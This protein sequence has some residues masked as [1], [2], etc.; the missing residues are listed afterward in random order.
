MVC[1][2][3]PMVPVG[4]VRDSAIPAGRPAHL[5]R[6][7]RRTTDFGRTGRRRGH[8]RF[9][10][11]HTRRPDVPE[12]QVPEDQQTVA[13]GTNRNPK[14][15]CETKRPYDKTIAA[16]AHRIASRERHGNRHFRRYDFTCYRQ[17]N[18]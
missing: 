3:C 16:T 1:A 15:N 14:R 18:G 2:E 17:L 13:S 10:P 12:T 4:V 5:Q 11:H 6:S 7:Q 9:R 8:V